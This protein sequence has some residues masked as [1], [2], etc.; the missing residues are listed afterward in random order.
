MSVLSLVYA[1]DPVFKKKCTAV[2]VVDDTIRQIADD[3]LATLE[4][5]KAVG[6]G[7]PMV[8]ITKQIAVVDLCENNIS[9]PYCFINPEITWRSDETQEFEEASLC[10]PGIS[11]NITRPKAIHVRYLDRDG[12][13]QELEA[14]GFLA[15]VIQH[16]M[17]YLEGKVFLDYLSKMKRDM[18]MRKMQ[19]YVKQHPPHVHSEH[20]RH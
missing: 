2:D 3:M 10:F 14:E 13:E 4:H 8:G 5:E 1:P 20:C 19:K 12:N 16:E 6:I 15:T 11:A 18:L 9:K 17:D 7:A